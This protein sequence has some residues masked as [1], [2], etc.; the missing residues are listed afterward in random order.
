[1]TSLLDDPASVPAAAADTE[2][3]TGFGR[4]HWHESR[5]QNDRRRETECMKG[6][7]IGVLL[8]RDGG[9]GRLHKPGI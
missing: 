2:A 1:M 8:R 4:E 6:G 5:D 7:V 3:A 9:C